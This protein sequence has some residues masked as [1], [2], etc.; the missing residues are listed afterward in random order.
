MKI[1]KKQLE[2]RRIDPED[3]TAYTWEEMLSF[4]KQTYKKKAILS[5]WETYLWIDTVFSFRFSVSVSR[6]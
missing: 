5:Y 6:F 2:E 4:Y 3:G 1:N